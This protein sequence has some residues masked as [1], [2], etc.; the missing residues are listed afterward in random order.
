[1]SHPHTA[2]AH[3]HEYE[4]QHGLPERLPADERILWQGG[5][6]LRRLGLRVFH[7]R[8]LALYFVALLLLR[9]T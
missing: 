1:M 4:P 6:D 3:E 9:T 2:H 7:L 5:P 8:K